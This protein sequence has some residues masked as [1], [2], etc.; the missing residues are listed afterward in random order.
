MPRPLLPL[1]LAVAMGLPAL[2]ADGPPYFDKSRSTDEQAEAAEEAAEEARGADAAKALRLLGD[3]SAAVRDAVFAALVERKD[4]ALLGEL[5]G[6]L[7]HENPLVRA[8]VAELFGLC[9]Y[10]EGR[11]P[12]EKLGLRARDEATVLE[13]IWALEAIG[14]AKSAKAL[15]KLA[16]KGHKASAF[17]AA[18]DALLALVKV[19]AEEAEE[20]ASKSLEGR[21]GAQ[22]IAAVEALGRLDPKKGAEAACAVLSAAPLEGREEAWQP[23]LERAALATL[24]RWRSRSDEPALAKRAVEAVLATYERSG[25]LTAHLCWRA[26]VSATGES[27]GG[28]QDWRDWW[29]LK[30][31]EFKA[32]DLAQEPE[33]R[34]DDDDEG[35]KKKKK[36]KKG[37][38]KKGKKG[39]KKSD[40]EDEAQGAGGRVE[41]GGASATK[42]RFCGVPVFSRRLL[43]L[44]DTSGGMS[45]HP[46]DEDDSESPLRIVYSMERLCEVLGQLDGEARVNV[47]FFATRYRSLSDRLVPLGKFREKL[48]GYVRKECKTPSGKGMTRSN[49]YDALVFALDDPGIDSVFFLSEGGQTEGRYVGEERLLRHLERL[50]V[51]RRVRVNCLQVTKKKKRARFLRE[52]SQRT[53]GSYYPRSFLLSGD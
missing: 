31:K 8:S 25:G 37:K 38:K 44:Q 17:C 48:I 36:D 24:A 29:A 16:R 35:G 47:L 19:D 12:L 4:D 32:R 28:A 14:S 34:D 45:R 41:T 22:R 11:A 46:V 7:R 3:P 50:N 9:R 39:K 1:C 18:G 33:P 51:Y 21:S 23:A 53:G 2:A 26:L 49:L 10:E 52:L 42:V 6:A 43:F 30:G 13:S 27:L 15:A 40:D 5:R 20:L